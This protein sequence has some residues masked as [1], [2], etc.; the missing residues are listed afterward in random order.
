MNSIE[1]RQ[2][3]SVHQLQG[4]GVVI[5]SNILKYN[6]V[7]EV[8]TSRLQKQQEQKYIKSAK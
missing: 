7:R 6:T 1:R 2:P 4:R 5:A 8:V 3:T